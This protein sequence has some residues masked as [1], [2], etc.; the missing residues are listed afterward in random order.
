MCT[1]AA[2]AERAALCGSWAIR[3][4]W[5]SWC[6]PC[7]A[8]LRILAASR[9]TACSLL[10]PVLEAVVPAARHCAVDRGF[11]KQGETCERQRGMAAVSWV[12]LLRTSAKGS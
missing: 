8:I 2:V 6:I 9:V 3:H 11:D 4:A 7:M 5:G 1:A 12:S 10:C